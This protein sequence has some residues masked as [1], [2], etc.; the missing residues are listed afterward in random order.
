MNAA[1]QA[2]LVMALIE[3]T[4]LFMFFGGGAMTTGVTSGGMPA[5]DGMREMG[6]T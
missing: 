2:V 1:T 6:W 5:S 4:V 3:V